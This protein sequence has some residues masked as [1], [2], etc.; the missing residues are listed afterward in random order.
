MLPDNICSKVKAAMCNV[1]GRRKHVTW[2]EHEGENSETGW[3]PLEFRTGFLAFNFKVA[4]VSSLPL[5]QQDIEEDSYRDR[6]DTSISWISAALQ[7]LIWK[8]VYEVMDWLLWS[9][10]SWF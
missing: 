8:S 6:G 10:V 1:R 7:L 3:I 5:Q 9:A 2:H 4:T